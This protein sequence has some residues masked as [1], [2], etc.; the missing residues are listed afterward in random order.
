[1][2]KL[3]ALMLSAE[4]SATDYGGAQDEVIVASPGVG[5]EESG[6]DEN[7]HSL[8]LDDFNNNN[9]SRQTSFRSSSNNN[10][11][12]SYHLAGTSASPVVRASDSVELSE[13]RASGNASKVRRSKYSDPAA[14]LLVSSSFSN[15]SSQV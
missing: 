15:S 7:S 10:Y 13:R 14:M 1:M 11:N 2:L 8:W 6:A 12:T 4:Q 5:Y 3:H 9:N